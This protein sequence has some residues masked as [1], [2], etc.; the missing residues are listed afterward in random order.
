MPT[1]FCVISKCNWH[2]DIPSAIKLTTVFKLLT[3]V[4]V[5]AD[6][7]SDSASDWAS[8]WASDSI[9][10][11]RLKVHFV[12]H[13]TQFTCSHVTSIQQGLFLKR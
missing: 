4:K 6:W 11:N 8:D 3:T 1:Q 5:A 13:Y 12:K 9:H 2:V 7:A 10:L